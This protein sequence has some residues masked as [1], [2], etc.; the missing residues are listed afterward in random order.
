MTPAVANT[1]TRVD[2]S[3]GMGG[4]LLRAHPLD[5][6]QRNVSQLDELRLLEIPRQLFLAACRV[7]PDNFHSFTPELG[8]LGVYRSAVFGI[9]DSTDQ[10]VA[11]EV[12]DQSGHGSRRDIEHLGEL[13][14]RRPA[15]RDVLKPDQ[16]LEATLTEAVVVR[17]AFHLGMHLLAEHADGRQSLRAWVDLP[18]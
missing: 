8:E 2:S 3:A 10:A 17:P 15:G 6:P 12:V 5:E 11:L 1:L 7:A 16:D 9:V 18:A 14:H 13:P 4:S